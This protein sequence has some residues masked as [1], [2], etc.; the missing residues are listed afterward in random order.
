M[1]A[2]R[3]PEYDSRGSVRSPVIY[4]VK[5]CVVE[6]LR[7]D[8]VCSWQ[9]SFPEETE[10]AAAVKL[11]LALRLHLVFK[12]EIIISGGKGAVNRTWSCNFSR[13]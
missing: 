7:A 13:I 1:S 4:W 6:R 9:I 3:R 8:A 5:V 2:G 10:N 11:S 12:F